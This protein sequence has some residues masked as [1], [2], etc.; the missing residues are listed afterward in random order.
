MLIGSFQRERFYRQAQRRWRELAR[1]AEVA[2]A[3]ADFS[4]PATPPDGPLEVPV[5]RRHP[6]AREWAVLISAGCVQACLVAWERPCREEL[7][8][9]ARQFEVLW[10]VEPDVVADAV[11]VAEELLA[12]RHA[13]VAARLKAARERSAAH[14]GPE[15]ALR[16]GGAVA[17]RMIGYL[18]QMASAPGEPGRNVRG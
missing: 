18:G 15:S 11:E 17:H 5:D 14:A 1:T 3:L 7:P 6:L 4:R 9:A 10:S 8:D 13:G 2:V 16:H 12:P